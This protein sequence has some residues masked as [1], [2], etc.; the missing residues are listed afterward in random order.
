MNHDEMYKQLA[1]AVGALTI[2]LLDKE[3]I[4]LDQYNRAYAQATHDVDQE[5][6]KQRD[7]GE[8]K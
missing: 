1:I 8:T 2:A 6:A 5:A 3:I 7:Q 4:S